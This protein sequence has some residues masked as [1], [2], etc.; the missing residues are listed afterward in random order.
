MMDLEALKAKYGLIVTVYRRFHRGAM[1]L[2]LHFD[3]DQEM[4]ARVKQLPGAR[5]SK[6][7]TGWY[8]DDKDGMLERIKTVCRGRAW[9]EMREINK[10]LDP[11]AR[12]LV[13]RNASGGAQSEGAKT[14]NLGVNQE[15]YDRYI[16]RLKAQGKSRSTIG[17]YGGMVRRLAVYY[18]KQL[19]RQLTAEMLYEYIGKEVVDRERS[20]SYHRQLIAA[21]KHFFHGRED[22]ELDIVSDLTYPDKHKQLPK[23]ISEEDVISILRST[24]NLKHRLAFAMLYSC[25]LR[26]GELLR[27]KVNEIDLERRTV[28]VR[29]SKGYKD[30]VVMLAESVVP[31]LNNY[32][33]TYRPVEFLLNGQNKLM[34]TAQSV[35]KALHNA[36]KEAGV[37]RVVTPHTLRHSFATH[38]LEQGVGLRYIQELLGHSKPETTMVY[39]YVAKDRLSQVSSPLDH[40]VNRITQNPNSNFELPKSGI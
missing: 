10:H 17:T 39:T 27:L 5:W 9:Y 4:I 13:R 23:V 22:L 2:F 36:R 20:N 1:R 19:I 34:Y 40:I 24:R 6:T 8:V 3:Y 25:G 21:L 18:N 33:A 28:F 32:L 35:R 37:E 16:Q 12:A 26:I 30:R 38:L 29:K 15:D 11:D 7:H 31:I 14:Q